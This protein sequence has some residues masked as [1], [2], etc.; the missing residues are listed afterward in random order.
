MKLLHIIP[1]F[2]IRGGGGNRACAE[3]CESLAAF[4]HDV[5][6]AHVGEKEEKCFS[7]ENVTVKAFPP[8]NKF[9]GYAY[10][11]ALREYLKSQI[12]EVDIVHIHATWQYPSVPAARY[13]K[14]KD[15]P[16]VV[17]PHGNLHPWKFNHKALKKKVYWYLVEEHILKNAAFIHVESEA[18]QAD[19]K[20]YLPTAETF[21]SPCGAYSKLFEN[22]TSP[23][24]IK[25]KWPVFRDKKCLLY[26][27]RVDIN[28]GIEHLLNAY[29][30]ITKSNADY[31][32]LIVGPDYAGTTEKMKNL[33]KELGI[34]SQIVWAGMVSEQERI[35]I[36]QDC[37]IYAL[38]SLSENFGISVLEAMF[39]SKPVLTTTGTPWHELELNNAGVVVNPDV[40]SIYEGL[41]RLLNCRVRQLDEMGLNAYRLAKSKYEWSSIAKLLLDKYKEVL[42]S[43]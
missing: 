27:A 12:P 18:D 14:I 30:K 9:K 11:P 31:N 26:L 25:T 41:N 43:R 39:C 15:I 10:S 16:Y 5:I 29:A 24:Y 20:R 7:P 33:A 40:D 19:V 1:G 28:K 34:E 22:R 21:I 2:E 3:L 8:F 13:C 36:M 37:D 17:Q 35:W 6:V 4:G 32:L 38:P 23:E 42:C